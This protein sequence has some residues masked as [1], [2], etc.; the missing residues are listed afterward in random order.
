MRL[1]L[2]SDTHLVAGRGGAS[3]ALPAPLLVSL[4]GVDLILHAGDVACREVL[5]GLRR[6]AP[7]HAVAGN[8]DPPGLGLPPRLELGLAGFRVGLVHGHLGPG[9]TT[10][11]RAARACPSADV[12]VFGHSHQPM[13]ARR[14][15]ERRVLLVNPGSPTQP[16]GRAPTIAIVD[17]V[18]GA[19]PEARLVTLPQ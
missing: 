16:R 15:A 2:I 5:E 11:E 18:E 9:S 13:I 6:V 19:E 7:V 4:A 12:V 10:P 1:G 17:L 14:T 8:V 3:I